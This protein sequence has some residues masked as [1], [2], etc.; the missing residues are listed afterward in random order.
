MRL[1]TTKILANRNHSDDVR[2][3]SV[4]TSHHMTHKH[5]HTPGTHLHNITL[6]RIAPVLTDSMDISSISQLVCYIVLGERILP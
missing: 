2:F 3:V 5:T 1:G 4:M 6:I